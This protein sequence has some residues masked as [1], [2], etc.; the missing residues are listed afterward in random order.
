MVLE[1]VRKW[2]YKTKQTK[3]TA[4]LLA[5]IMEHD[6]DSYNKLAT[7]PNFKVIISND[8]SSNKE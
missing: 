5:R 4:E 8:Y 3:A 6:L 7:V 1:V 2:E